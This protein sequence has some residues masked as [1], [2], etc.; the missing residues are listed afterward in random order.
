MAQDESFRAKH[1]HKKVKCTGEYVTF[2]YGHSREPLKKP[3][4]TMGKKRIRQRNFCIYC[5]T[6]VTN[7]SRHVIRNHKLEID[8]QQILSKPKLSND[9]KKL[10]TLLRN[11][12]NFLE[13]VNRC[14]NQ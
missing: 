5:E 8:V 10:L 13:N 11:K 7:F 2:F 14:Q 6:A 3:S 9:R 1:L 4:I 12:G